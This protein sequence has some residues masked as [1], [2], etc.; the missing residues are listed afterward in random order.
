MSFLLTQEWLFQNYGSR[1]EGQKEQTKEW[2]LKYGKDV[3]EHK[4]DEWSNWKHLSE[5]QVNTNDIVDKCLDMIGKEYPSELYVHRLVNLLRVPYGFAY[6]NMVRQYKPKTILELGVGGD[7]A[8]STAIF[9]AWVDESIADGTW[10][11]E[12]RSD[13]IYGE[14]NEG[15]R[16]L[17][18]DRNPLDTTWLRYNRYFFWKFIQGDSVNVLNDFV[19]KDTW[20]E[21]IFIDTIHSYTHTMKELNFASKITNLMLMDDATFE[22]NDF[23][24]EPGGV[25]RAI[26]EWIEKN[27]D[28]EIIDCIGYDSVKLLKRK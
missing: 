5:Y 23:D 15:A 1:K 28:W 22:G 17:S 4:L 9:L 24:P 19:E 3:P 2:L 10:I 6:D 21:M 11:R 18:V 25:K 20:W 8:I 26:K 27:V 7:S 14:R 12:K 13:G 16:L